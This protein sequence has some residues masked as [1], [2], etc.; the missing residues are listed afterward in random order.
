MLSVFYFCGPLTIICL[1]FFYFTDF[2]K[3]IVG[4]NGKGF[5]WPYDIEEEG[6]MPSLTG[7][8]II[9]CYVILIAVSKNRQPME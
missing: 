4:E 2:D 3:K 5:L 8:K 9:I 7:E 1:S 6:F